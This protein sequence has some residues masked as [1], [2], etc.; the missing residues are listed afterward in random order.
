MER[1]IE[2]TLKW[3]I[4]YD[5]KSYGPGTVKVPVGLAKQ[6]GQYDPDKVETPP[7]PAEVA[8]LKKQVEDLQ[9]Q[10]SAKD[11]EITALKDGEGTPLPEPFVNAT[12]RE[13]LLNAGYS[14][15]E[16]VQ[17]ASDEHLLALDGVA[18]GRLAEIRAASK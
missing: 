11:A 2:V 15:L 4:G 1:L 13:L 12:V 17:A 5:G 7:E 8:A 9:G 3:S 16:K 6:I 10:L 14:T 18:E